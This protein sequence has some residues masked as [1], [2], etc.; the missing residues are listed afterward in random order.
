MECSSQFRDSVRGRWTRLP[1]GDQW[2]CSQGAGNRPLNSNENTQ[3]FV[4]KPPGPWYKLISKF[5]SS[6]LWLGHN[7]HGLAWSSGKVPYDELEHVLWTSL[8][9]ASTVYV[10]GLEKKQWLI[11]QFNFHVCN[12]EDLRF[13][14]LQKLR[15]DVLQK[16]SPH[17]KLSLANCVH[18]TYSCWKKLIMTILITGALI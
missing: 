3:I 15:A 7:Y 18:Q 10:K 4:F 14:T 9:N 6:N 11:E 17:H 8:D 5:K 16:L 13:S 12:M 1:A 2:L